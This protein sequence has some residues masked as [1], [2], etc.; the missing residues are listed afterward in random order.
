[1]A[2]SGTAVIDDARHGM[3]LPCSAGDLQVGERYIFIFT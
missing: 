3:K 1:M 2:S